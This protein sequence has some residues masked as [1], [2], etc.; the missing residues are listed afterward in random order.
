MKRIDER[1]RIQSDKIIMFLSVLYI[2]I[3]ICIFFVGWLKL[4]YAICF[5]ALFIFL[6]DKIWKCMCNEQIILVGKETKK[7]WLLTIGVCVF[8]VYLSGIGGFCYQND[9]YWARNPIFRDLSSY[10]WPVI[11]DNSLQPEAVRQS[12][13]DDFEFKNDEE[14]YVEMYLF[15]QRMG[16]ICGKR[17]KRI[18][19][20]F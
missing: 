16:R 1:K 15:Y 18:G 7:Y 19:F 11:Y 6:G 3:P 12:A 2:I 14:L 8:W 13:V 20:S 10:P 17:S 5:C 9:D 4:G